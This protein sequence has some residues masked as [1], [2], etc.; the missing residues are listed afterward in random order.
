[1]RCWQASEAGEPIDALQF[2]ETATPRQQAGTLLVQV[3]ACGL[4]MADVLLCRGTYQERPAHPFTPGIEIAGRVL[5][6][7]AESQFAAGARVVG[8]TALPHG[9]LAEVAVMATG[10]AWPLRD[11]VEPA[12]AAATHLTFQTA[13]FGLA[14]R[15]HLREGET[16]LVHAGAGATGSAAIQLGCHLG[17]RVLATAGGSEK[18][19]ICKQLG[20]EHAWDHR[21][22][23]VRAA[24][25][26]ATHGRGADVI[27]DPVAGPAFEASRR[28]LAF[29]GRL[30]VVGLTGGNAATP[31]NH[32]LI[33]N[34]TVAGLHWALYKQH[35]PDAVAQ[36]QNH[37]DTLLADGT[38]TPLLD[39]IR[40]LPD[41]A[42]ALSDLAAGRST[43][44]IVI[45]PGATTRTDA[46]TA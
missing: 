37:I 45:A 46:R 42:V 12:T 15:A 9:G 13:W 3:D 35:D 32:Q 20:A 17:A 5:Q 2:V 18:V 1:M 10:D 21:T 16:L 25:L 4:N 43:G 8:T 7:D 29:E 39:S 22:T 24:V 14:R 30:I 34:Y 28:A 11:D 23:D 41:A 33:K 27:F 40:T 44:K 19:A 6:G 31:A 36:A 38:I 26:E